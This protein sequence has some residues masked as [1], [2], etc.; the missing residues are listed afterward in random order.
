MIFSALTLII[1]F[2]LI[3]D[4][5]HCVKSFDIKELF[6]D[7]LSASEA[8]YYEQAREYEKNGKYREALD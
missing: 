5:I 4:H 3:R 7:R 6:F 8:D 2:Q 1:T